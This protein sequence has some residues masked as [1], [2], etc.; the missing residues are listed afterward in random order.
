MTGIV[1]V[2]AQSLEFSPAARSLRHRAAGAILHRIYPQKTR[3]FAEFFASYR[4]S[5]FTEFFT[6]GQVLRLR[7][8]F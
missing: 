2:V 5:G 7:I 8:P 3:D 4:E 1:H 6:G